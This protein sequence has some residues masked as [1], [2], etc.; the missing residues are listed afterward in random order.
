MTVAEIWSALE[1]GKTVHW[2]SKAYKITIESARE[3]TPECREYWLKH[4]TYKN[5]NVLRATCT[6]NWFGSLLEESEVSRCFV[7]A[8]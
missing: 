2:A 7:G 6:S 3:G 4:H 8:A 5:G 1:S